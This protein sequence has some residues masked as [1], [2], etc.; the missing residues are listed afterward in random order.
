MSNGLLHP[1]H[2]H[3]ECLRHA[4]EH[5]RSHGASFY[6]CALPSVF[7]LRAPSETERYLAKLRF[8]G[9]SGDEDVI[10]LGDR[11][12]WLRGNPPHLAQAYEGVDGFSDAY[13]REVLACTGHVT[14]PDGLTLLQDMASRLVNV[15]H[16]FRVTTGMPVEHA[17]TVHMLGA[18]TVYGLGAEDAHTMPSLL[19]ARLNE[20]HRQDSTFPAHRV[21]NRGIPGGTYSM[22]LGHL[23]RTPLRQG[24]TVLFFG[25][26]L[27]TPSGLQGWA[28]AP[29][30]TLPSIID[31]CQ[32]QG[33]S[34]IDAT[35]LFERPHPHGELF[36]DSSHPGPRGNRIVAD[37]L[38]RVCFQ[39]PHEHRAA[40]EDVAHAL[41]LDAI[42]EFN[43]EREDMLLRIPEVQDYLQSLWELRPESGTV[44][45][46][47]M[48]CNPFTLGHRHLIGL[49]AGQVDHLFVFINQ[50]NR[51]QFN[52]KQRFQMVQAGTT[53]LA[54]VTVLPYS[55]TWGTAS[56]HPQYFDKEANPNAKLDA[57]DDLS[58]FG[59]YMAKALG[60]TKRFAGNEPYCPVTSQYNR[61]MAEHMPRYGIAY[62]EVERHCIDGAPVSA[63]AVRRCMQQADWATLR[64]LV[65]K[66]TIAELKNLGQI[67]PDA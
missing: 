4:C 49:A 38:F 28:E 10:R 46:I 27:E 56:T 1:H 3:F 61:Q 32:S 47:V 13:M 22:L 45:A 18:S 11:V 19:Q 57:T 63:S 37:K 48:N 14:N 60:I 35:L 25:C 12:S 9:Q 30:E 41:R 34:T 54:N 5:V 44:G 24:D 64:R 26:M 31:L 42:P 51:Q 53:D 55:G 50:E 65:P 66:S 58:N 17:H 16:G 52:F 40:A 20:L 8:S 7:V 67:P 33:I 23:K 43:Q 21:L 6:F 29:A 36:I 15:R 62:I 59:R 39:L 2:Y